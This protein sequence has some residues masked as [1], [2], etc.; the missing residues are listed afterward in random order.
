VSERSSGVGV[1]VAV[2]VAVSL[3]VTV[4]VVG[5]PDSSVDAVDADSEQ[6]ATPVPRASAPSR[7]RYTRRCIAR[8]WD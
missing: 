2:V 8:R 3:A 4:S 7:R 5:V 1:V 6:P